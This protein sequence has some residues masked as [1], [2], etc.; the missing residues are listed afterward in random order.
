VLVEELALA[1][2]MVRL[3]AYFW[4]NA[5]DHSTLKVRSALMRQVKSDLQS[6]GFLM[7]DLPRVPPAGDNG[8]I[9]ESRDSRLVAP[10]ASNP[11]RAKTSRES[12]SATNAEG[13]LRSE[14]AELKAQAAGSRELES[15]ADL[16]KRR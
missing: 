14:K 11:E 4:I 15:G 9:R 3:H 16:L 8:R 1:P 13:S 5:R 6:G 10:R 12:V 2:P 7:P